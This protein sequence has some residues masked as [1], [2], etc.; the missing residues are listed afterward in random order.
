MVRVKCSLRRQTLFSSKKHMA[1][2]KDVRIEESKLHSDNH[3]LYLTNMQTSV[4]SYITLLCPAHL[5]EPFGIIQIVKRHD[6][7]KVLITPSKDAGELELGSTPLSTG[8]G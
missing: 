1:S 4:P 2:N 3:L 6:N 7:L 5:G 8:F